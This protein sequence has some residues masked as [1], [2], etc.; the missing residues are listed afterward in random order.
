MITMSSV[1]SSLS[2]TGGEISLSR[3]ERQSQQLTT[4][5]QNPNENPSDFVS[6]GDGDEIDD[7]II[8]FAHDVSGSQDVLIDLYRRIR[9]TLI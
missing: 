6:F 1:I 9:I 7:V 8:K 3:K 4:G 5:F 2:R